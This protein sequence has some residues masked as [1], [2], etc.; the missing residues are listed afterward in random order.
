MRL[1]RHTPYHLFNRTISR[2]G[3]RVGA[4]DYTLHTRDELLELARR[5][6]GGA[7]VTQIPSQQEAFNLVALSRPA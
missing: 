4:E 6:A 7:N 5:A 3:R 2:I 1:H